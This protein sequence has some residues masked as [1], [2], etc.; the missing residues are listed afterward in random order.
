MYSMSDVTDV[1][2]V[3][4]ILII[5]SFV[6]ILLYVYS[7]YSKFAKLLYAIVREIEMNVDYDRDNHN[8]HNLTDKANH[9]CLKY[10]SKTSLHNNRDLW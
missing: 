10:N 2:N 5:V 4:F 9:L 1:S 8:L 7:V 3:L 6:L